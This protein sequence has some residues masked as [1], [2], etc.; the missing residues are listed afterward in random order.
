MV[1]RGHEVRWT[2]G[3]AGGDE[4]NPDPSTN[5]VNH[6]GVESLGD[7]VGVHGVQEDLSSAELSAS[8]RPGDGVDPGGGPPS[9]SRDLEARGCRDAGGTPTRIH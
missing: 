3:A 8:N 7:P 1:G 9:V 4:R 2:S 5:G 6:L